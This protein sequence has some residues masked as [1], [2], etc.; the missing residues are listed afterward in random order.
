MKLSLRHFY[1]RFP[2]LLLLG[3][4]YLLLSASAS[5][6]ISSLT[7][8][9]N[10]FWRII[11]RGWTQGFIPYRDLFDN[12]GPY[13]MLIY[14]IAYLI[15]AGKWGI[16]T[17]EIINFSFVLELLYRIGR[18][19]TLSCKKLVFAF[20]FFLL[21]FI[22]PIDNGGSSEEWSLCF[23]LLPLLLYLK[24]AKSGFFD[25]PCLDREIHLG[26]AVL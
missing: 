19:Y 8:D 1:I 7:G 23:T 5:S 15:N 9:D 12:K 24:E 2:L 20:C 13:L 10:S 6:P 11:G 16:F 3:F 18:L 26:Q 22:G 14:A 17:L 21:V 25:H 4:V